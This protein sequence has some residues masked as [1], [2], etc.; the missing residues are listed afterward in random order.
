MGIDPAEVAFQR[1][2]LRKPLLTLMRDPKATFVEVVVG[3]EPTIVTWNL[4]ESLLCAKSGF[5]R[6]AL[7]GD[8]KEAQEKRSPCPKKTYER[9][10][11]LI[12]DEEGDELEFSARQ[13]RKSA[14]A[15]IMGNRLLIDVG[16]KNYAMNYLYHSLVPYESCPWRSPVKN[17]DPETVLYVVD[18][19]LENSKIRKFFTDL[20]TAHWGNEA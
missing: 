5:F 9:I 7:Q 16:F 20:L 10:D 19:A 18:N 3:T 12:R 15:W 17:L 11:D 2:G 13:V 4:Y 6:G 8:F 1:A 14:E